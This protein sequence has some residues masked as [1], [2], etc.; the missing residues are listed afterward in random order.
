MEEIKVTPKEQEVE[1]TT[2]QTQTE[3]MV[4]EYLP[5]AEYLGVDHLASK[6]KTS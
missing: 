5:V 3:P 6:R 4:T 2:E 1:V